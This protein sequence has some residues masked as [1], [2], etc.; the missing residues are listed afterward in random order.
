MALWTNKQCLQFLLFTEISQ[1]LREDKDD[2]GEGQGDTLTVT[3][4][5]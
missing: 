4:A 3:K 1:K 2:D 5:P